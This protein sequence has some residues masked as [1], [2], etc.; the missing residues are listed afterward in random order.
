MSKKKATRDVTGINWVSRLERDDQRSSFE[1]NTK[2][3]EESIGVCG[4]CKTS[5]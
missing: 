2:P 4:S 1:A 5:Q 3:S